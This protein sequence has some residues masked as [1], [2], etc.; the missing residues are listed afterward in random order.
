MYLTK[1]NRFMASTS[2][3]YKILDNLEF[4]TQVAADFRESAD[5]YFLPGYATDALPG[6]DLYNTGRQTDGYQLPIDKTTRLTNRKT[7]RQGKG[8]TISLN[9]RGTSKIKK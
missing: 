6:E 7:S 2:I 1:A 9:I 5:E 8:L 3:D 4:R